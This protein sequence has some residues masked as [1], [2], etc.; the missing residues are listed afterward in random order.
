M[1]S[2]KY[3]ILLLAEENPKAIVCIQQLHL[4]P[5]MMRDPATN[6]V[7]RIIL[8]DASDELSAA[9]ALRDVYQKVSEKYAEMVENLE[10]SD[11]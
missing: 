5:D 10:A 7:A 6:E 3:D 9:R 8:H 2:D 11:G 1:S 4:D